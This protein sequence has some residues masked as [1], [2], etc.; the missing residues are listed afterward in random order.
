MKNFLKISIGL[1]MS[2]SM[3]IDPIITNNIN[4]TQLVY[5]DEIVP[6]S[7]YVF[8]SYTSSVS[9]SQCYAGVDLYDYGNVTITVVLQKKNILGNWK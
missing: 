6:Y 4:N 3:I 1:L 2:L 8:D 7:S 5:A 9:T